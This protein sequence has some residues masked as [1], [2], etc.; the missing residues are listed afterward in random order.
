M[1][2]GLHVIIL[3]GCIVSGGFG[4]TLSELPLAGLVVLDWKTNPDV[5]RVYSGFDKTGGSEIGPREFFVSPS[6]RFFLIQ[7]SSADY[8]N[9]L[10][11]FNSEIKLAASIDPESYG[12]DKVLLFDDENIVFSTSG[13]NTA[14][15]L[16]AWPKTA[17]V[18]EAQL[19][20]AAEAISLLRAEMKDKRYFIDAYYP[21]DRKT[22]LIFDPAS[23]MI[24]SLESQGAEVGKEEQSE[25]Y[26]LPLDTVFRVT[27]RDGLARSIAPIS[28][29]RTDSIKAWVG[30]WNLEQSSANAWETSEYYLVKEISG[31]RNVYRLGGTD[32]FA[33]YEPR[34]RIAR[35]GDIYVL[36]CD[37]K[38]RI[39]IDKLKG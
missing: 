9:P 11:I 17:L 4:Q 22:R 5:P 33:L 13:E 35:N 26:G 12:I 6:G 37:K 38:L 20:L 30:Y 3:L 39:R 1:R 21:G 19:P 28:Y 15:R 10:R 32:I 36:Y 2:S 24:D 18:M 14:I 29:R 23:R 31:K 7:G 34:M 25:R 8:P 16:L 27:R